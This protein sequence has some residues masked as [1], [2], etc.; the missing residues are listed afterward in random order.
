MAR[1]WWT[2]F[3]TQLHLTAQA[4]L[5]TSTSYWLLYLTGESVT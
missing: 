2:E 1:K 5:S 4:V 3:Q